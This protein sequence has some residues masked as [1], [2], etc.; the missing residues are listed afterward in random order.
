[1]K[2]DPAPTLLLAH[3]PDPVAGWYRDFRRT[4]AY[5]PV[6]LRW[7]TVNDFFHRSDRP[8]EEVD[9]KLDDYAP[10]YLAQ[11]AA[12]RD[13]TPISQGAERARLRGM[14]DGL[15]AAQ[16][17]TSAL[18]GTV[19]AT[20][21]DLETSLEAGGLDLVRQELP[22]RLQTAAEGLARRI[23]G[24][25]SAGRPGYLI[26]N[27]AG[28]ARR[29]AVTLPDA[30]ADLAP[31][32]P[33][34]AA[35][36]TEDGVQAVVE[37]APFGY[38]WVARD[39]S[40]PPASSPFTVRD[41]T[42]THES[43]VVALDP[44]TGGIRTLH[45]LGEETPR[46][47]QQLVM[48]GFVG[49]DGQPATSRM[50]GAGF[51]VD[52]AGP[53]LLRATTTG[54]LH[55]PLD[56]RR[57]ARFRQTIELWNGRPG[58]ELEIELSDL[59]PAWL[60][61]AAS[62]DPWS[63]HLACRWAW[64][65]TQATLRR[66]ALLAPHATLA[67]HAETSESFDITSRQ[68]RTTLLFG[69]LAHHRRVGARMLDTIL[70]AG[71]ET[72]RTFRLGVTLDLEH[73]FPAILDQHAPA[74]V[75]VTDAGPPRSGPVG[76]LVQVDHKAVALV[77]FRFEKNLDEDRGFGLVA[78]L[79]ETSGKPARCRLRA[80]RD[81]TSARQVDGRG[82]HVVDLPTDGDAALVDLTPHE[83]ARVEL[84]LP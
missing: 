2:D 10:P 8:F 15:I 54:T 12:R 34:K 1:M 61:K 64:P 26:L 84:N 73:P 21:D 17:L 52:Y 22:A 30:P 20:A 45:A 32:G 19:D 67:E 38:A 35:Q 40:G 44:A 14:L 27:L 80:F 47:G 49:P 16:A 69:G 75:V 77:G 51:E 79:I 68:R 53:A 56:D 29:V 25:G 63:H 43:M 81:P 46:V 59:D 33:L 71:S 4:A 18:D 58:L 28:V 60:A 7:V 3:W 50:R 82:E 42:V 74:P 36:L 31:S 57:L 9:P 23:V 65:D 11:A 62:S 5:S 37:L 78:D 76:W 24:E 6:L 48:T 39:G 70:V 72:A 55:D 66:S 13:P 83:I 41:R